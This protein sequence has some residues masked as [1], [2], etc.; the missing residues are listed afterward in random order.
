[1][2][3]D[4]LPIVLGV[5]GLGFAL[6]GGGLV[7]SVCGFRRRAERVDGQLVR[8]RSGRSKEGGT[9]YYPT[10]RFTTVYGQRVEAETASGGGPPPGMPGEC[11]PVLYDPARPTRIRIDDPADGVVLMGVIFLGIG[12]TL[13]AIG[14]LVLSTAHPWA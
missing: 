10:V 5:I 8:L 6:I 1:V 9:V 11:V 7:I 14:V 4:I 13:I 2:L 3:E 12:A